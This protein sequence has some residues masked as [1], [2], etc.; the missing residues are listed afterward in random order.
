MSLFLMAF[1]GMMPFGSLFGGFMADRFGAPA[2][3]EVGGVACCIGA[4][5]FLRALPEITRELSVSRAGT[6]PHTRVSAPDPAVLSAG[7]SSR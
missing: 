6:A 1:A 5:I 2:T 7:S 3:L 4:V